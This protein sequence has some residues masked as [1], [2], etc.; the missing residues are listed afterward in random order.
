MTDL[1]AARLVELL[2]LDVDG[3][4]TDGRLQID[5]RGVETKSFHVRDGL[6]LNVWRRLGGEIA[7]ITGRAGGAV[8]HRAAELGIEHVFQG[9]GD[10]ARV[11]GELL[12]DT[13]LDA[14]Q[15]A[16]MGDD[17][18]DL[19]VLRLAGY[20]MAPSDAAPEVREIASFVT[21]RPGGLGAVREAVEHLLRA[22]DRWDEA[23][24]L[25][26]AVDPY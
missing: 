22:Q 1:A 19:P 11:F 8:R 5:D 23:I 24:A 17:L 4:L 3:V 7:I 12:A 20:P 25:Y 21:V 26:D 14:S 2:V 13:G 10:K 16:M 18:P 15:T 6:G 9:V